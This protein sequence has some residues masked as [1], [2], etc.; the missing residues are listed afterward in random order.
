[1]SFIRLASCRR[2]CRIDIFWLSWG[3]G[4]KPG[5]WC[6]CIH[7]SAASA[8]LVASALFQAGTG[9]I[10]D[11]TWAGLSFGV[12]RPLILRGEAVPYTIR[13]CYD[14]GEEPPPGNQP[15]WDFG[16]YATEDEAERAAFDSLKQTDADRVEIRDG[17]ETL[18]REVQ[19]PA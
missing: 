2:E 7:L 10:L 3:V 12:S 15:E 5:G 4:E 19:R 11:D 8:I 13:I 17:H 14:Q 6:S 18:V 9:S 16:W 1:M